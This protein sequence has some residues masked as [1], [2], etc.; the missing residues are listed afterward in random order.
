MITEFSES[1]KENVRPIG[2]LQA[3]GERH[4]LHMESLRDIMIIDG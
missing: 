3:L 4:H 2:R 1:H